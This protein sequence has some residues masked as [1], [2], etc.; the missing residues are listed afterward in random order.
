MFPLDSDEDED[1]ED[2][3]EEGGTEQADATSGDEDTDLLG[4]VIV[5]SKN[6]LQL[7]RSILKL[8]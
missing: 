5:V 3:E 7:L 6:P 8:A 1:D 2:D 4:M